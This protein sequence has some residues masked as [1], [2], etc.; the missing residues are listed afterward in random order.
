MGGCSLPQKC[1]LREN[2]KEA[3][4]NEINSVFNVVSMNIKKKKAR[5]QMEVLK[6]VFTV[7]LKGL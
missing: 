1:S 2:K 3:R 6:P 7:D 5:I 4:C